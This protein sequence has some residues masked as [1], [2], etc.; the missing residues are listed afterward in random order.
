MHPKMMT[1]LSNFHLTPS[2]LAT[3]KP[4]LKISVTNHSMIIESPCY[5][6]PIKPRTST[7]KSLTTHVRIEISPPKIPYS[8]RPL[9]RSNRYLLVNISNNTLD[10]GVPTFFSPT[11]HLRL[12]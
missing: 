8:N 10:A 12:H 7:S 11:K 5:K 2:P 9:S 1:T 4:E 3:A 6:D